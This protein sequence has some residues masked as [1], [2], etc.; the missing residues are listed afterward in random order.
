MSFM[1]ACSRRVF[2]AA[3][4]MWIDGARRDRLQLDGVEHLHRSARRVEDRPIGDVVVRAPVEDLLDDGVLAVH[5]VVGRAGPAPSP[6]RPLDRDLASPTA[7]T[8]S[9]ARAWSGTPRRSAAARW[10]APPGRG[11]MS[12]GETRTR[13]RAS[14]SRQRRSRSWTQTRHVAD[15]IVGLG[16][17]AHAERGRVDVG[18]L[19]AWL[20][21]Q[22]VGIDAQPLD[23]LVLEEPVDD[24]HVGPQELLATGDLLDG[25]QSRGGRRT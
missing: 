25:W 1:S 11:S 10:S 23:D 3:K 18:R 15:P 19:D 7:A 20:A 6:G 4:R 5:A 13:P 22:G 8:S 17:L 24:D 9:A 2:G 12:S 16:V 21:D 14:S